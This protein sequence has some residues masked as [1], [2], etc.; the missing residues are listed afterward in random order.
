MREE[1][2][3]DLVGVIGTM[4]VIGEKGGIG[5][6]VIEVIETETETV[7]T[8]ATGKVAESTSEFIPLCMFESDVWSS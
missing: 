2:A 8:E 6:G 3:D 4:I 5:R 7:P 1:K